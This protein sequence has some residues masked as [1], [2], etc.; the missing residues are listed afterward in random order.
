MAFGIDANSIAS[1]LGKMVK[2]YIKIALR[3]LIKR[4]GYTFINITGLAIGIACCLLISMYVLNELSYDRFNKKAD[5]IYR[6]TQTSLTTDETAAATTFKAG[7]MLESEY[8]QLIER[9]VRFF[10][11]QHPSH[12]MLHRSSDRS[13]R[14]SNFYFVDSTF[15]DVFSAKLIRG[16]PEE[17]LANPLSLVITEER[18]KTYFGDENPIG[19]S[20]DFQGRRS[21]SLK[22]TGIME[23][24]PEESHMKIDM[25][26]SFSSVDVM[27][28]RTPDYDESWWW[29]PV[30]TYIEF[31]EAGTAD[32]LRDQLP[33]FADK[34]YHPNR[35]EGEKVSLG[36]QSLT[37]I[38]LYSN[39]ELEMNPN[40]S[41]FYVYLF[42]AVAV[43][44]LVIAC[45]NFMNLATARSAERGREVGMRKV[46]GAD[47]RQL[48]NQFMGESFLMTFLAIV[49]AIALVYLVMPVF[50]DFISKDLSFN[51]FQNA[52][53]L[54]GLATLFV[55]VALL[56]GTYPALFLSGF[57]PT[58][59]LKGE[60][61][62]GKNGVLFRKGLVVFQF[63]L[64]VI[65][66]IGTVLLYLQLQHMQTKKL[67][68]DK[69]QLVILPMN[70]NLIAWEFDRFREQAAENPNIQ[71]ITA[72]SK[73]LG[74]E[75]QE[76][77]KIYPA[78]TPQDGERSILALHTT[79]DFLETYGIN[80]IA[81]RTFSRDY[82]TDV[83]QA[84]LVNEEM[85]NR[86]D[87][88]SPEEA[89]GELFYYEVSDDERR[90]FSV[91]GVTEN[92]NYASVKK[93][94]KP[95]VIRLSEGTRPILQTISNAVVKLGSGG[96]SEGLEHLEKVWS[97]VNPID[98]FEY[99]FQDEEL[100]KIF[101]SEMTLSKVSGVF[102]LLCILVACL[103]LFGL[104]S[105]TAS[106]RTKEIGIR[107]TFGASLSGILILLSKDYIKLILTAN[108]IAWPVAYFL[109]NRWLQ[110]FPYRIELGW[111]LF[112]VFGLTIL[113]SVVVCLLTV[114]YQSMK[115]ALINPVDSIKQE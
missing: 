30:W 88:D 37:D 80:L 44:I 48:F 60:A 70:Q 10:D 21:M 84:I 78:N 85:L 4:K 77:W 14:E 32:E 86:L 66:I 83:E 79:Y 97:E 42:S 65:L 53:L 75:E 43:L 20:L 107:K 98:P 28:R 29:N 5:R 114:S 61:M 76:K 23:E 103:G 51:I 67:G 90:T 6:L 109:V 110:D 34:Y 45:V 71:T 11:M 115:A 40:S 13:F 69:E 1:H 99:S 57:Q 81:G 105:F 8:P 16:N 58:T 9:S 46:L 63:S 27:Y 26:A 113:L 111:N 94:I 55:I 54:A 39:L 59:I 68:F 108:L 100:D 25:L 33:A 19:Q 35:P 102:T 93:E 82:P 7:P 64:S 2:N 72:T 50:N 12:T 89:I 47:R 15:F 31:K 104:A 41:I 91:I 38:H 73:V 106:K 112:A 49:L 18:A 101:A 17:V 62:K 96:V 22:V 3:N 74:S 56:A 92:F 52:S 24:W 87:I 36:L 95:L